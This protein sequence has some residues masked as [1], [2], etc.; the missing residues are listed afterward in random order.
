VIELNSQI[1]PL[2]SRDGFA[3]PW[4]MRNPCSVVVHRFFMGYELFSPLVCP[5]SIPDHRRFASSHVL[6]VGLDNF[7]ADQNLQKAKARYLKQIPYAALW[8][9]Q[10]L[11]Q[12]RNQ[13][14]I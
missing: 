10:K 13:D 11:K 7:I 6:F 1:F 5:G 9:N 2:M 4:S 14:S 3:A 12:Q 8:R